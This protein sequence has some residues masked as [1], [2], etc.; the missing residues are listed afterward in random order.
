[1]APRLT[2][3]YPCRPPLGCQCSPLDPPWP[4]PCPY[5]CCM[6][7]PCF[8]TLCCIVTPCVK[9]ES[10]LFHYPLIAL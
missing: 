5:S 9:N 10:S 4:A 8:I 1:L 2:L 6:S 7:L 3:G